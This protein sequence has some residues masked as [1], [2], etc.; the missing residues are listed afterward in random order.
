[1]LFA[2][3]APIGPGS[4]A[5]FTASTPSP[6]P[7]TLATAAPFV[8]TP[9]PF[10][11]AAVDVVERFVTRVNAGDSDGVLQL[12]LE[13]A[14]RSGAGTAQYPH[15]PTDARLWID[16]ELDRSRVEGFV[17]YVS[18]LA[19]SVDVSDCTAVAGGYA[20]LVGCEYSAGGGA[21]APLGQGPEAGRLYVV[22]IE[23][24]VAGLIRRN[25]ADADLW[26]R[27]ADWV[28]HNHPNGLLSLSGLEPGG[29]AVPEYS[30]E[31]ALEQ[32][33]LAREMAAAVAGGQVDPPQSSSTEPHAARAE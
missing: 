15:L 33:R 7:V 24:R 21:L 14:T 3:P 9:N 13:E 11:S 1:M 23:N 30:R 17:G 16:G 5:V 8:P 32:S 31:A 29:T 27:F 10:P 19:G 18:A 26:T 25:D 2:G 6:V 28:A 12:M 22:T 4:S 20:T